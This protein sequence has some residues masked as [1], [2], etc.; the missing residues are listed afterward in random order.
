[1]LW[2]TDL[3]HWCSCG[4]YEAFTFAGCVL[5]TDLIFALQQE[6]RRTALSLD[7]QL[8]P[9]EAGGESLI[10]LQTLSCMLYSAA[11]QDSFFFAGS[12]HVTRLRVVWTY[13]E[14]AFKLSCVLHTGDVAL[15]A[16]VYSSA[17]RNTGILVAAA[18][19]FGTGVYTVMGPE[20][21]LSWFT[22]DVS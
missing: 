14:M 17:L 5:V 21:G 15:E 3:C 19:L 18:A 4:V 22:G 11:S 8:K 12:G 10:T 9:P 20:A 1:M 2:G 16:A 7:M 6:S 13:F